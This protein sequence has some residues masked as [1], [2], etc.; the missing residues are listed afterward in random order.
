MLFI[1]I[2]C[3]YPSW[4]NKNYRD[5]KV[6]IFGSL[7]SGFGFPFSNFAPCSKFVL[8]SFPTLMLMVLSGFI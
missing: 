8:F 3:K 4:L 1:I 2:L 5:K 6:D 7:G